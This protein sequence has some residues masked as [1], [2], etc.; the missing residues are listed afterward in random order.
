M[1]PNT[2]WSLFE[3][4][5]RTHVAGLFVGDLAEE[6]LRTIRDGFPCSQR[7]DVLLPV[8][9]L[10]TDHTAKSETASKFCQQCAFRNKL[11]SY[12]ADVVGDPA[13]VGDVKSILDCVVVALRELK[14]LFVTQLK[15]H[16][17]RVNANH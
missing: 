1:T 3:D 13:V 12:L 14:G 6:E 17:R 16:I 11:M 10:K 7:V 9:N 8:F 5:D 4:V 2:F 15:T